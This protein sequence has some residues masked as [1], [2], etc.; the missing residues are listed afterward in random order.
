MTLET[1]A[2]WQSSQYLITKNPKNMN[3][4]NCNRNGDRDKNKVDDQPTNKGD[5]GTQLLLGA[6]VDGTYF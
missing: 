6:H 1:M 5:S 2:C 4:C 3:S